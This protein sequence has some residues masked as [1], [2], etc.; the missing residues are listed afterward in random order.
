MCI[1]DRIYIDDVIAE[2]LRFLDA[3]GAGVRL[4]DAG[5]VHATTVGELVQ[6]IEAFRDVRSTLVSE[7]VGTGLVR[8]LYAT[9]VSF[10]PPEAFSY[11][12]LIHI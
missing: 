9:Y 3:P 10:L 11:L 12:S 7:R 2:L 4:A 6:Q 8:A 5:P 1:R